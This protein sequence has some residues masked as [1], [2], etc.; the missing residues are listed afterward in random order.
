MKNLI[1]LVWLLSISLIASC[2][3]SSKYEKVDQAE[4]NQVRLEF[5][6]KLG[7]N[8]LIAQK[9]G[10]YY[11]LTSDEADEKMISGLNENL[12]KKA[13]EQIKSAFGEYQGLEF[14]HVM[15]PS[16]GT[17]Y[18]IYRFRGKFNPEAKAEVRIVLN[19]DGKLAGFFVK[20]WRD[21]L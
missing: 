3:S 21:G 4:I 7:E 19:A 14:D 11:S 8:I 12:Q 15:K 1:N 13:Y 5:A 20:P 2:Q 6:T 17:L 18:E 16:D 9:N 10:G